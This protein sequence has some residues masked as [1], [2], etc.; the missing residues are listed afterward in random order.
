MSLALFVIIVVNLEA[1]IVA[2]DKKNRPTRMEIIHD[3]LCRDIRGRATTKWLTASSLRVLYLEVMDWKTEAAILYKLF[4]LFSC[5]QKLCRNYEV[6]ELVG[7][8]ILP[9]DSSKTSYQFSI[10]IHL[11]TLH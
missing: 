3:T 5:V 11:D 7:T 4:Q 10:I 1:M 8:V 9:S 6:R 2:I